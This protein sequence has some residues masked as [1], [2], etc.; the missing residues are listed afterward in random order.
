[1]G[2]YAFRRL[3]IRRQVAMIFTGKRLKLDSVKI[4]RQLAY[5]YEYMCKDLRR[6]KLCSMF[7][8]CR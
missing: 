3:G 2:V 1:M 4:S 8:L 6:L 5:A 7:Y